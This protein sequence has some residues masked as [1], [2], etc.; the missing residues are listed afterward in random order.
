[1][2]IVP[3]EKPVLEN[4]NSYYLDIK[5]LFEHY[6]GELGSGCIHF[7]SPSADGVVFFDK[8][9]LLAGIFRDRQ[10]EIQGKEAIDNVIEAVVNGNFSI[11]IYEIDPEKVYFWANI[12]AAE[13][14]YKDLSTEFT[15]LEGL[16]KKMGSEK[17]TGYIEVSISDGKES[18]LIFFSNGDITGGSYSWGEGEVNRSKESQDLLIQK[19]KEFGGIFHVSRIS[20][21][22]GDMEIK[23]E[24]I[25]QKQA[26]DV[27]GLIEELM[28]ICER[29]VTLDKKIKASFSTLLK[30]KFVDKAEQYDFL[31]PFSGEFEYTGGKISF[32]GN[33]TDEKL[34]EG[35]IQSLKEL[36]ADLEILPQFN[37]ELGPW[38][39]KHAKELAR[40]AISI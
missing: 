27:L 9:E 25:G 11:N 5:K 3:K 16:I 20:F 33:V 28:I 35:V 32:R 17:L 2:V 23:P 4:L 21:I 40:L 22:G 26:S 10:G 34:A 19:T 8:D 1:M 15:D 39:S 14:I 36:A 30:K 37:K 18:G 29:I 31:D 6:Q 7:K 38:S 24:G 12:H 13:K